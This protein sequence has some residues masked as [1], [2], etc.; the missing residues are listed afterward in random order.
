M[1]FT[2][3]R[4]KTM[5]KAKRHALHDLHGYNKSRISAQE[6]SGVICNRRTL[7]RFFF[8]ATRLPHIF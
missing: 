7:F 8:P 6:R 3:K 4:M 2:M 1:V 5:K